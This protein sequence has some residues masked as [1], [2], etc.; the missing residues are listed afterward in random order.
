M[1]I[2]VTIG[3][4]LLIGINEMFVIRWDQTVR[5]DGDVFPHRIHKRRLAREQRR[6]EYRSRLCTAERSHYRCRGNKVFY[7]YLTL[8]VNKAKYV[9]IYLHIC[10]SSYYLHFLLIVCRFERP[11]FM[12]YQDILITPLQNTAENGW[13][14]NFIMQNA[15]KANLSYILILMCSFLTFFFVNNFFLRLMFSESCLFEC[16]RHLIKVIAYL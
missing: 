2:T 6:R 12:E 7:V 11:R 10:G 4:L 9:K 5:D 16:Y 15:Q 3:I 13:V 8:I 14:V 1:E